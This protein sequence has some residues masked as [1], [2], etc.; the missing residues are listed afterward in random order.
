MH[1]CFESLESKF[2]F[3]VLM[4]FLSC[5]STIILS[6]QTL[7]FVGLRTFPFS[8]FTDLLALSI[9]LLYLLWGCLVVPFLS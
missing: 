7:D 4:V 3:I 2:V 1:L 8:L 9:L 6:F 5:V